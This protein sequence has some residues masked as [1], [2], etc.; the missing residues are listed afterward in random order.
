V[1]QNQGHAAAAIAINH[2]KAEKTSN[3]KPIG[4]KDA[5]KEVDNDAVFSDFRASSYCIPV[6]GE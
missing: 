6:K 1:R 3:Q 2:R 4:Q 5:D